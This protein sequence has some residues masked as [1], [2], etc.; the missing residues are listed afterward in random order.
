MGPQRASALWG[1]VLTDGRELPPSRIEVAGER[2]VRVE[3][4]VRP[5]PGDTVVEEDGWLA[6]GLID[7]QVNG[8][9]GV[10]LTSAADP[11]AAL[12]H[13]GRTLAQ[14]GVTSFC[15]TIVILKE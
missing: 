1:R 3:P 8:A 10:D 2:I 11:A 14:H 9:A 7:L 6:P 4:S 12:D 5:L 15:P 13:V